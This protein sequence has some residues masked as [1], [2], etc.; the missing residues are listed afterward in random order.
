[1]NYF[2]IGKI[3][4]IIFPMVDFLLSLSFIINVI[5]FVC[6]SPLFLF[7]LANHFPFF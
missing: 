1:M 6:Y 4:T 3:P 5:V 2:F 7:L